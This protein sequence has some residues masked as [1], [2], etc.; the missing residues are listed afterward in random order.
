M[1]GPWE[2][3]RPQQTAPANPVIAP[4]DPYKQADEVRAQQD[5]GFEAQRLDMEGERLKIAQEEARARAAKE[6]AE[7]AERNAKLQQQGTAIQDA[8]AQM[9]GVI[10]AAK[11]AKRL[12][13]GWFATGFGAKTARDVGGTTAADVAALLNTIGSNT[14]FDRLQRMRNE[15]PTGGA[16]GAVSEVELQLLRDSIA[17]LDQ[18]QSDEQ[19][20][21]NMDKV[22]EAYQRVLDRIDPQPA[23]PQ[24]STGGQ[25]ARDDKDGLSGVVTDD[26]PSPYDPGGPLHPDSIGR[27]SDGSGGRLMGQ[28]GAATQ[29]AAAGAAQGVA[30]IYDLAMDASTGVQRGVNYAVGRGGE[31]LLGAVGLPGAADWWRQGAD[32]NENALANTPSAAGAI[33]QLSPTPEGMAPARFTAQLLGGMAVPLGPKAVPR[34]N[35]L[36]APPAALTPARE[37]IDAGRQAGVRVMTSDVRPPTTFPGKIA[38]ATGERIPYAGTGGP[39]AAQ[40]AERVEAVKSLARDVGADVSGELLEEVAQDFASTR[41]A[42]LTNLKAAKDSVIDGVQGTLQP[43]N[44]RRTLE[45]IDT[46]VRRLSGIDAEAYKPVIDRLTQFGANIAS[47]KNLRQ[48]EGNRAL[49]GELFE[50]ASLASI[51][52]EGQKAINAIYGPLRED[53]GDFIAATAGNAARSRWKGAN[54]RLS[55]MAG[56]LSDNVFRGVLRSSDATPENVARLLFSKKPS[57]VQRL[58]GNLSPEGRRKAQAAV[59]QRAVE[60]AG[61]IDNISPDRFANEVGRLGKSIGVVFDGPG[62][63]RVRGLERLLQATKQAGVASAAPPTGAQ[64]SLP[65]FAAV[66]AD[67]LGTAGAAITTGAGIGGLA[68]LYESGPV[69]NLLVG[70]SK[71]TPGSQGESRMLERI[72]KI[73]ASQSQIRGAP[74][75]DVLAASPGR[76]AAQDQER[77]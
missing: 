10:A 66:L 31:A 67:L 73:I 46:Q 53:M 70:L 16:L 45:A 44:V 55:A 22:I 69:R 25:P 1:A 56:E 2:R 3:Y 28:L 33:E 19:F 8:A 15:S 32:A 17:S 27:A 63:A 41:G 42:A 26:T 12:S 48:I 4:P 5:Q 72:A 76:L 21:S 47:G 50:D 11:D 77:N 38:R 23:D 71:T 54:D 20:Q 29:N 14:A 61:G 37:V 49:L 36:A 60:R 59:I 39:R 40:Q 30:G 9:R 64:N 7:A 13:N 65:I 62:L 74:A 68:R 58:V 52:G 34:V 18:S 35:A 6:A 57:E 24:T 51:K 75:N 43:A